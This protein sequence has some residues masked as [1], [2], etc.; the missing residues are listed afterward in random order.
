MTEPEYVALTSALD[1]ALR[2][3]RKNRI[4]LD[5][6][7]KWADDNHAVRTWTHL[8]V[9]VRRHDRD[10]DRLEQLKRNAD[11]EWRKE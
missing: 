7:R 1:T 8:D 11:W 4:L 6:R 3:I 2:I 10:I 5:K 9:R